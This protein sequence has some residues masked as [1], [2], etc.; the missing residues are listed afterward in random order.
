MNS[1]TTIAAYVVISLAL[2]MP[3]VILAQQS[4][5]CCYS[6]DPDVKVTAPTP[7]LPCV[8]VKTYNPLSKACHPSSNCFQHE[9]LHEKCGTGNV[10]DGTCQ[11]ESGEITRLYYA[12]LCIYSS[13]NFP[14]YFRG[15]P[16]S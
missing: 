5:P 7:Q 3:L 11:L 9:E 12:P 4:I 6:A 13:I 10:W 1:K 8:G 15:H 14:V 16:R 2:A